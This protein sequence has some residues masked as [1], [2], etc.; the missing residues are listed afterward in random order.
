MDEMV[1][2]LVSTTSGLHRATGGGGCAP[3]TEP[4]LLDNGIVPATTF[5]PLDYRPVP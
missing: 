3:I 4:M 5:V 1:R 2:N